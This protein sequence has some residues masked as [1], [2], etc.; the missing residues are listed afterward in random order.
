M[1]AYSQLLLLDKLL[2]LLNRVGADSDNLNTS[3]LEGVLL[4]DGVSELACLLCADERTYTTTIR[5]GA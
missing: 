3:G 5:R 1:G 2:L 4:S